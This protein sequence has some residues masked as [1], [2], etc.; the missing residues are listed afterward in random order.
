[1]SDAVNSRQNVLPRLSSEELRI[2][3][4]SLPPPMAIRLINQ[5]IFEVYKVKSLLSEIWP[6]PALRQ[7]LLDARGS[8][9]V[10]GPRPPLD[11]YD[12]KAVI[13][14]VRARE[15]VVS[16][17]NLQRE[18]WVSVRLVPPHGEPAGCGEL[19]MFETKN[20]WPVEYAV[21]RELFDYAG[22]YLYRIASSS[23]L[24][25]LGP[26]INDGLSW[27][28][29]EDRKHRHTAVSYALI[30]EQ[31]FAELRRLNLKYE[32]LT[33]IIHNRLAEKSLTAKLKGAVYCIEY[34][35]AYEILGFETAECVRLD[36]AREIIYR[37][38]AYWLNSEELKR[39]IDN[40]ISTGRLPDDFWN[41]W[42]LKNL[43]DFLLSD[44]GRELRGVIGREVSDGPE[45]K[46]TPM[47]KVVRNAKSILEAT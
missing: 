4:N 10:Y 38:P 36:R 5:T 39:C 2:L 18:E 35:P 11:E 30:R 8:Y 14:L 37:Y 1:M 32:Y 15:R 25:G 22:N 31:Y 40:M 26:F 21:M 24:C 19:Q 34:V 13:Y 44:D 28:F 42:N 33:G 7:L 12:D 41:Q 17:Y 16:D 45:L 3:A 46:I 27:R 23:R 20:G 6:E 9:Y 29:D 47:A 43:G